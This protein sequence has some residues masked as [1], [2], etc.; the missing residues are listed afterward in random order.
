MH[1]VDMLRLFFGVSGIAEDIC[2]LPLL[3]I[4]NV[5]RTTCVHSVVNGGNRDF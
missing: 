1:Y 4:V 5:S 2:S 3:I